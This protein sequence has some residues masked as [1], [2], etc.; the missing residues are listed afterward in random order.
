MSAYAVGMELVSSGYFAR[1][2]ASVRGWAIRAVAATSAVFR[3]SP[4]LAGG[5]SSGRVAAMPD[6]DASL[7]AIAKAPTVYAA[8]T[9]AAFSAVTY[10]IVVMQGH[11]MSGRRATQLDPN[12]VPWVGRLLRLLQSPG[13]ETGLFEEPGEALLAQI[14][15]DL[16][17]TG[18]FVVAPT[19]SP[20]GEIVGLT[21]LHPK[22]CAIE[23]R[24]G[25]DYLVYSSGRERR[26]YP[27]RDV[28]I[29]RL[30]S[31][32]PDGRAEFGTGAGESL[33]P[34]VSAE[35]TALEQTAYSVRQGGADVRIMPKTDAAA[36]FLSVEDNRKKVVESVTKAI[37][38]GGGRRVYAIGGAFD[39]QDSGLKPADLRAPELMQQAPRA[40]LAACGVV[41][42]MVGSDG[43]TYANGVL[44]FRAQAISDEAMA[45]VI[46]AHLL[47]PLARHFAKRAGGRI[48]LRADEITARLDLSQ[49]PGYAYLRTEAVSRMK[50][51][52]DMGWSAKQAAEIEGMDVPA[53][54]GPPLKVSMTTPAPGPDVG[55]HQNDPR[56]P[57]GDVGAVQDGAPRMLSDLFGRDGEVVA[58][59]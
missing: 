9:V 34:L 20:D 10:P 33:R 13:T 32:E 55:S 5:V 8:M 59:K 56:A 37:E 40:Q 54:L 50:S 39:V 52:V 2:Y 14:W 30:L 43:G 24:D 42:A 18:A 21:R 17:M 48:A 44:Q 46:E 41:P 7:S 11:P 47:R 16:R 49:H 28:S 57:V 45:G 3:S 15:A 1:A 31:W 58:A 53:P 23:R 19:L 35:A 29:G 25:V 27:R 4:K 26:S 6:A 12:T 22:L 51:W 38:G 36:A